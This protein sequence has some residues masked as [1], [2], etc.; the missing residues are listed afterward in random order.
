MAAASHQHVAVVLAFL[1]L[2]SSIGGA[3]GQTVAAA[4][5]T[6]L[7]PGALDRNLPASHQAEATS[8]YASLETQ[9]S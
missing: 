5:W 3:I 6:G 2:F 8:I 1:A 9:L 7:M 4:I